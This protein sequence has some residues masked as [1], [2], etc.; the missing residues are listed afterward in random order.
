MTVYRNFDDV[1]AGQYGLI[2]ADP[3][4]SFKTYSENGLTKSPQNHY[5]CASLDQ[6]CEINVA[7]MAAPDCLLWLWATNPMLP[8]ALR[9]M[10]AWG[11]TFKTAGTWLKMSKTYSPRYP[12]KL[13]WGTGYLLRSTNEPYLLGVRGKPKVHGAD[14]PSGFRAAV[15][16]HSRKPDSAYRAAKTLRPDCPALDLYSREERDG[17]D[18]AGWEVGVLS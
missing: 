18:S 4:W 15:R 12:G 16:E 7:G 1:P 10:E 8:Q 13:S 3:N 17:W 2:M 9:V 6:I 11:F 14:V 5:A